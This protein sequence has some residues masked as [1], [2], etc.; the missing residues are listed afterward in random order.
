MIK[1]NMTT[2][3]RML[4]GFITVA[5]IGGGI[6][7]FGILQINHLNANLDRIYRKNLLGVQYVSRMANYFGEYRLNLVK[8]V[9]ATT[10]S[11]TL[12]YMDK[13]EGIVRDASD[14][15]G[16]IPET[17]SDKADE[18]RVERYK[19]SMGA[20]LTSAGQC[21]TL[22]KEDKHADALVM[23]NDGSPSG[24]VALAM[25]HQKDVDNLVNEKVE[26]AQADKERASA[27][28]VILRISMAG[29]II[30][31][32]L[33]SVFLGII[34]TRSLTKKLGGEPD[35]AAS[36][37]DRIASGDVTVRMEIKEGDT[38][39]LMA[40]MRR[41]A[42]KLEWYRSI[43]DAVP[44][45]IHVIDMNMNWTFLN[46]AFEKLMVENGRVRDRQDAVGR[47]CSTAS[48]N[49]CKTGNCGIEQLR[50]GV[51]ESFF[52]WC[53]M[54]CKQD[55]A[56]VLNVKGEPVGY[57]ETVTDLTATLRVKNYTEE[58]VRSLAVNLERLG[59]G[60]FSVD[61]S[62]NDA[63]RYTGEVRAQFER[64]NAS[65]AQVCVSLDEAFTEVNG[66]LAEI[67]NGDLTKT[68]SGDFKGPFLDL[69]NSVNKTVAKLSRTIAEVNATADS[70]GSASQ[71][72]SATAQTLSQGSSEQASSIEETSASIEEMSSTIK[73][74]SEN[75]LATEKIAAQ[76]AL[77]G[78]EAVKS[79]VE[80]MKTVADK[81]GIIDDIALQ[82]NMLALNAAIE[83]ARAGE[84]GNGFAVVADEVRNLATRSQAA[85]KEIGELTGA[86]TAMAN[87]LLA[88]LVPSIVKT[89]VLVRD[90]TAASKE[91]AAGAD[92]ISVAITQLD[93][94]SQ[95]TAAASEQLASTSEEMSGQAGR[96]NELV[97]FFKV[98][99]AA[100]S[101][102]G[103]GSGSRTDS[104]F[105]SRQAHAT[106]AHAAAKRA[107]PPLAIMPASEHAISFESDEEYTNA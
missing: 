7:V 100:G 82:T 107:R 61:L 10:P 40:S 52:D 49:I 31:S 28:G 60:N 80:A 37:A 22:L 65:L 71:Q 8:A 3:A 4:A 103:T 64:I 88:E 72:V 35:Q 34:I 44:F 75:A 93:Q 98:E 69:K 53:G 27:E 1:R 58:S 18:D 90:I 17:N 30:A 33:I 56:H 66:V 74:N 95:Q 2:A 59:E 32:L 99:R 97:A 38:T 94:V 89:S 70:L 87:K 63:D 15:L 84:H 14:L 19:A 91:Q 57:V 102:T 62:L 29:A 48:A 39:S 41:L 55:T 68:V 26:R 105:R 43:I 12:K 106:A 24:L 86:T 77:D 23:M 20:Y 6:G 81:I 96:L 36:V 76:A 25:A 78:E 45:P 21:L 51:K 85:A 104:G 13:C 73:Q 92:Q 42:D 16:K 79:M 5:M 11:E 101:G 50:K 46:K 9:V 83:A 47:P 54:N 67:E